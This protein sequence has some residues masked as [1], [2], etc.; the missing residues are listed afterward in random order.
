MWLEEAKLLSR[1]ARETSPAVV[2]AAVKRVAPD[3]WKELVGHVDFSMAAPD[4][5]VEMLVNESDDDVVRAR[6]AYRL[7]Y[8]DSGWWG[9]Q[10][11]YLRKRR[12][13]VGDWIRAA[14]VPQLRAWLNDVLKEIDQLITTDRTRGG[15]TRLLARHLN[16]KRAG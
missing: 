16:A 3:R 13:I 12:M 6:A 15:R 1:L 7:I 8:P 4:P 14:T 5:L 9:P 11:E 10:S 2:V